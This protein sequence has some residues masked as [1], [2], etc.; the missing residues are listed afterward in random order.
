MQATT[1]M[2]KNHPTS[3]DARPRSIR[4]GPATAPTASKPAPATAAKKRP[5]HVVRSR[6]AP[7]SSVRNWAT[8]TPAGGAA[9]FRVP[10][11]P[12]ASSRSDGSQIAA[13]SSAR[14][15]ASPTYEPR[16][17][18]P[19]PSSERPV[20]IP[21]CIHPLIAPRSC[22]AVTEMHS[23]SIET[24][25]VAATTA[26]ASRSIAISV[27]A[28]SSSSQNSGSRSRPIRNCVERIHERKGHRGDRSVSTSGAQRNLNARGSTSSESSSVIRS[29]G[30]PASR[31]LAG[32]AHQR[33]PIGAP[34][35]R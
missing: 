8:W 30:T 2:K 14:I 6:S 12:A 17:S 24:S 29:I 11:S 9:A 25:C 20:S 26:W 31:S 23:A 15:P 34:S 35:L 27:N 3:L 28:D 18:A 7:N 19:P 10:G 1:G 4:N 5:N 33:N 21:A 32:R 22:A 16:I 13:S